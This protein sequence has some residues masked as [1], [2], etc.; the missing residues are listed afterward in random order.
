M[1]HEKELDALLHPEK[2]HAWADLVENPKIP[3]KKRGI[4]AWYFRPAPASVPIG[5]CHRHGKWTL[6]YIG[7]SPRN[8][9]S[10]G[11]LHSRIR[12][13]FRG[14]LSGSTLRT[15]LAA[16]LRDELNAPFRRVGA[17]GRVKIS[18]RGEE[19]LRDWMAEQRKGLLGHA[20]APVDRR[21]CLSSHVG[22][23]PQP[24]GKR[25]TSLFS[26]TQGSTLAASTRGGT[27]AADS[28]VGR[29]N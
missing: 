7:I 2:L 14:N 19:Q 15:S 12:Y 18:R 27:L 24:A 11:T 8:P 21:G 28:G 6:L 25:I 29:R 26:R 16:L 23:S 20:P 3:A 10:S 9:S 5:G 13:H 1:P 22:S 4:Y 17:R